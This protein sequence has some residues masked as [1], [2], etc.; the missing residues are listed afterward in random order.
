MPSHPLFITKNSCLRQ[1]L[2]ADFERPRAGAKRTNREAFSRDGYL[3]I[4]DFLSA[5]EVAVVQAALETDCSLMDQQIQLNDQS[6]GRTKFAL[7]SNP[8]DGAGTLHRPSRA[9]K[10][11]CGWAVPP[12][13]SGRSYGL[14][15][16]LVCRHARDADAGAAG[17]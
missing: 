2:A 9:E 11:A 7:W 16:Q 15:A 3:I 1:Q 13:L 5:G 17:G 4:K 12:R 6:G 10:W 14:F 8:G